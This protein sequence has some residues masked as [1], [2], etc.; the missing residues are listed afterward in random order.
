MCARL[1]Q[2]PVMMDE[3][4][5]A[6]RDKVMHVKLLKVRRC[7]KNLQ[8]YMRRLSEQMCNYGVVGSDSVAMLYPTPKGSP[9]C[10]PCTCQLARFIMCYPGKAPVIC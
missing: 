7:K 5:F 8:H 4:R 1:C 10:H 6:V 9:L 2:T 3:S